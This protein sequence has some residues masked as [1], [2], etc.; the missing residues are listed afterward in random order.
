[1]PS[2]HTLSHDVLTSEELRKLWSCIDRRGPDEC[3]EWQ[4]TR[5]PSK[6]SR[7]GMVIGSYGAMYVRALGRTLGAHRLVF[8]SHYGRSQPAGTEIMHLCDNPPCCN[9]AHLRIGTPSDN[10]LDRERK[11]RGGTGDR[12]ENIAGMI[13]QNHR[14]EFEMLYS[15]K[16]TIEQLAKHFSVSYFVVKLV[17]DHLNLPP[18]IQRPVH[19]QKPRTGRFTGVSYRARDAKKWM[20]RISVNGRDQHI[21]RFATEKEAA[22]AYDEACIRLGRTPVNFPFATHD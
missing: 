11:G 20:A 2:H 17:M 5:F 18:R 21:G 22:E 14:E 10:S 4:S 19:P 6:G 8:V 12:P 7:P 3:W 13:L 15:Q 1:M 16:M 9:P